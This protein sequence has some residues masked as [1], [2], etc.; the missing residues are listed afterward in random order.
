[1]DFY[2]PFWIWSAYENKLIQPLEPTTQQLTMQTL[3]STKQKREQQ[4]ASP[5]KDGPNPFC[6]LP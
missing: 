2:L 4:P 5:S 6:V 1:M 3:D